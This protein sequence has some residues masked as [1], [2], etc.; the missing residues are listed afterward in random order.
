MTASVERSPGLRIVGEPGP[1]SQRRRGWTRS[2]SRLNFGD[3]VQA[4]PP[5]DSIVMAHAPD[6]YGC[7]RYQALPAEMMVIF[8][9]NQQPALLLHHHANNG[10][11]MSSD[12]GKRWGRNS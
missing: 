8:T 3:V 11:A 4:T 1:S 6:L 7:S 2:K 5:I 12:Q 10:H 9:R